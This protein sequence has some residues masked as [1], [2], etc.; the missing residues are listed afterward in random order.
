M[1]KTYDDDAIELCRSLYHKYGGQNHD[2]IQLGM[3]KAGY[4]GWQKA[5]LHDR[6]TSDRS[7]SA[8]R[9]GWITKYGFDATLKV[10]T[11]L[12]IESVQNDD[13]RDYLK[14]QQI[15]SRLETK[16]LKADATR[17]DLYIYRDFFRLKL[18]M[19]TKLEVRRDNF[20]T[21]VDCYDL[22]SE[23]LAE[24]DPAAAKMMVKNGEKLAER[25]QA[26]YGKTEA[27]DNGADDRANEVGDG[28]QPAAAELGG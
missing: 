26:H 18:E 17:D 12:L 6:G 8:E 9:M 21:F 2:A 23:W 13:Q 15:C 1:A 3:R 20:E 14:L 25:A 27:V 4:A 28:T 5:N 24:I 11:Q 22:I 7:K 19:K 16:A 10:H